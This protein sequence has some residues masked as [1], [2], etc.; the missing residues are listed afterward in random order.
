MMDI[1]AMAMHAWSV[2][3]LLI[4]PDVLVGQNQSIS[5]FLDNKK[6][7]TDGCYD[8]GTVL[9]REINV[10]QLR[11]FHR[12]SREHG[13]LQFVVPDALLRG[14]L[15]REATYTLGH[16]AC[17]VAVDVCFTSDSS[18]EWRRTNSRPWLLLGYHDPKR[19]GPGSYREPVARARRWQYCCLVDPFRVSRDENG[20]AQ[21]GQ[22]A[23]MSTVAY[24]FIFSSE[25]ET[26]TP[27]VLRR[28]SKIC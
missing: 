20:A 8:A 10:S 6:Q 23:E 3:H 2:E 18:V 17:P 12:D 19:P 11:S 7:Y 15:Q 22:T 4:W 9:D 13:K 25:E 16:L 24:G 27:S 5:F 28:L 1:G 21:T 14:E 26:D